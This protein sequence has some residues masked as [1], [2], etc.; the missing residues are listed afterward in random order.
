M[1]WI[2]PSSVKVDLTA[3][4]QQDLGQVVGKR[5]QVPGTRQ[6]VALESS[7]DRLQEFL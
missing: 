2:A 3:S 1:V 4:R 7:R 6:V 5:L